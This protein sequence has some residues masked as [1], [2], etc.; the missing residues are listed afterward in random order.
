MIKIENDW[1]VFL[2]QEMQKPYFIDLKKFLVEE[3]ALH[4]VYPKKRDLLSALDLTSY[5]DIKVVII[6]Q[7]PYHQ[8]NQ[9]HGLAFSVADNIPL[10]PS[11]KNIFKEIETEFGT[12]T[13]LSGNLERWAKQGVLLLNTVLTVRRDFPN[14]HQNKGW[15]TFT[16]NIIKKVC[17][18][19]EPLVFLLWGKN[20]HAFESLITNQKHM[21]LKSAHP[22]PLSAH[23]GF[24][25]NN[26]FKLANQYLK[27]NFLKEID[28]R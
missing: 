11:L 3:Y 2:E 12:K 27:Q 15:E 14:S 17:Q 26:H 20:A 5:K 13:Y 4:E 19:D 10:P 1:K 7:D 25:G 18:K 28:W 21:V 22:S 6:G 8:P 9:A 24:L 23:R 16:K